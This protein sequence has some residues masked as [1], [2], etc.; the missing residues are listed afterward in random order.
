M[1]TKIADLRTNVN[2]QF[3]NPCLAGRSLNVCP[4]QFDKRECAGPDT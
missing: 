1:R 4:A 3:E 2:I